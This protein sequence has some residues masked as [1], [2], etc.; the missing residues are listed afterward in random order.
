MINVNDQQA[1]KM[2]KKQINSKNSMKKTW[3]G[4]ILPETSEWMQNCKTIITTTITAARSIHVFK[5]QTT[6]LFHFFVIDFY[7]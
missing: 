2:N 5:F 3:F 7:H 1:H 6:F 4:N